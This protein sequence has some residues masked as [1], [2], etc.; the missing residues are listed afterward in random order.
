MQAQNFIVSDTTFKFALFAVMVA[1][2][3]GCVT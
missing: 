1:K 2:I 3:L